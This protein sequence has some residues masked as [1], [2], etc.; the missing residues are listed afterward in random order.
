M[1]ITTD[2]SAVKRKIFYVLLCGLVANILIL[3]DVPRYKLAVPKKREKPGKQE[4][5]FLKKNLSPSNFPKLLQKWSYMN[6]SERAHILYLLVIFKDRFAV[7]WMKKWLKL[8]IKEKYLDKEFW[9]TFVLIF[10][11]KKVCSGRLKGKLNYVEISPSIQQLYKQK[12]K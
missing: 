3:G 1:G 12:C 5:I 4:F 6:E 8:I 7:K 2:K 10:A 9:D 11:Q